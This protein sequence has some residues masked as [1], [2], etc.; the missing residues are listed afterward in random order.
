LQ[1]FKT[2]CNGDFNNKCR[3]INDGVDKRENRK[4]TIYKLLKTESSY[5]VGMQEVLD[6]QL[7]DIK[8]ELKDYVFVK[9]FRVNKTKQLDY[10]TPH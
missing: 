8:N 2:K 4:E 7:M 5:F 10:K 6:S 1:A 9:I 3:N